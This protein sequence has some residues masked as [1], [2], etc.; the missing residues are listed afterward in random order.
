M[1]E[2]REVVG[3]LHRADRTKLA[4]TGTVRG[5]EPVV[6]AVITVQSDEPPSGP[7]KRKEEEADNEPLLGSMFGHMSSR[8][9]ERMREQARETLRGRGSG[10]SWEFEPRGVDAETG[11]VLRLTRFKGGRP[12]LR[13]EL[14]DVTALAAGAD[15][16]F[17]PPAGLPVRDAGA[18]PQG[19][20]EDRPGTWGWSRDSP[21]YWHWNP[22][23]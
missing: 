18:E 17:T 10:P 2:E 21:A 15:F 20:D 13:Q 16:G 23:A 19:R 8:L 11:L 5:A 6:D 9:S 4:L 22:P 12:A 7:W 14:R 1:S 3:L